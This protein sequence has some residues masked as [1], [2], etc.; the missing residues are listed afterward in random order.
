MLMLFLE[1]GGASPPKKRYFFT[2]HVSTYHRTKLKLSE[3]IKSAASTIN[4][5]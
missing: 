5:E 2:F 1:S 3:N 4:N